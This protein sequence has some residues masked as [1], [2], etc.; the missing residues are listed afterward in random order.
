MQ[1][2]RLS[3]GAYLTQNKLEEI[4]K[5]FDDMMTITKQDVSLSGSRN[6]ILRLQD[7]RLCQDFAKQFKLQNRETNLNE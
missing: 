5:K 2:L 6:C 1:P 4:I 7:K 3:F